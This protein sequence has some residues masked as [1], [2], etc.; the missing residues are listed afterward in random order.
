[1]RIG[2]PV[3]GK[4]QLASA[5]AVSGIAI[6]GK[7]VRFYST[8]DFINA[9]ETEKRDGK[10]GHIAQTLM[11]MDLVVLVDSQDRLA[12]GLST[13]LATSI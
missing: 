4:T 7:R 6:Q 10:A 9:L 1:M 12:L 5:V 3:N 13:S 2:G 11:R 8:F